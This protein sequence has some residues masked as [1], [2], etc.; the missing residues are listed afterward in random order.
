MT[1]TP[2]IA[3]HRI[4][5]DW[6]DGT[7]QPVE[8]PSDLDRPAGHMALADAGMVDAALASATVVGPAWADETPQ[9][10][11]DILD[12]AGNLVLE[13]R[14]TLG[15][16]L[17]AEEGKILSEAVGEVVRAGQILKFFA[18][19][20]LR[21][22][23]EAGASVR[24]GVDVQVRRDPVGVCALITPWNF[25][26]AIPAWKLAPA[27]AFG[28][29]VVL[30]PS[31]LA[32]LSAHAL[33]AIL[34]ESGLPPG[35]VNLLN[36]PGADIGPALLDDP[37]VAAISFTGSVAT[38]R[39]I[40]ANAGKSA[41]RVQCE[42][43]GKNALLVL[44][45]ADLEQAVACALNG[46]FFSTGQR[47][48]A[49]SRL[50]VEDKVH[51][52]FV[53]LVTRQMQALR[54]GPALDPATQM[55]PVIDVHQMA[56]NQSYL[57]IARKQ[58]GQVTGGQHID[59]PTRGHFMAPALI[60]GTTPDMRINQEE[61]FGPVASVIRVADYEEG[62]QVVNGTGFGLTAGICTQSLAKSRHFLRHAQAGMVMVNLPTAGVDYHVPFGG[63]KGSSVGPREQ[64]RAA[65]DFYTSV[66]TAYI[67]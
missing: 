7:L 33:V 56:K 37:R 8:N 45:D 26:I 28:N 40:A 5:A 25:P 49:S 29:S 36:G 16:L 30:K 39:R 43:G 6:V 21:L 11:S 35:V 51:D 12:R 24:R 48:T 15:R 18:G 65:L 23:G 52:A 59:G 1:E 67:G 22:T 38:G 9:T 57:D 55:G 61:V 20:A 58:G 54:V 47:C 13:R 32:P 10:R 62:L 2:I 3:R 53:A 46:A 63:R 64:G 14:D 31:E 50:V 17:A 34:I 19:E 42:M 44:A 27:L 4:G 66:K 60:T 41:K